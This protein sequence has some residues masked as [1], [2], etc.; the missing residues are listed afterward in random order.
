MDRLVQPDGLTVRR[1]R[2]A[3]GWSPHDLVAAISVA[4]FK[5]SGLK[6]SLTPNQI[7]AIEERAERITYDAL[8]LLADGLDCDPTDLLAKDDSGGRQRDT[9][10]H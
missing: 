10:L 1:R 5:A 3:R 6:R 7:E 8:L 9:V 4:S 2:H